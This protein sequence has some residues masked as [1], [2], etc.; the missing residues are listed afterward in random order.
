MSRAHELFDK[1]IANPVGEVS[2]T[3]GALATAGLGF[4][5]TWEAAHEYPDISAAALGEVIGCG[6]GATALGTVAIIAA[7]HYRGDAHRP[8]QPRHED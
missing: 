3:I 6:F 2:L 8:P 5:Q 1:Y 4:R 7:Q